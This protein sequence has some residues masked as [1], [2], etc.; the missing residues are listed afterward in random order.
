METGPLRASDPTVDP[1]P[2]VVAVVIPAFN[3]REGVPRTLDEL[4]AVLDTLDVSCEVVVV[5]DGSTDGTG[6]VAEA[7]GVRVVRLTSN[8]GYGAAL[9]AGIAATSSELVAIIDADGTYPADAL[10]EL[11]RRSAGI[12]MV[13]GARPADSANIPAIRRPGKRLLTRLAS[14]LS[15]TEIPDL[16]SGMR[17][18]RRSALER[19]L[20]ILPSGF[21]FTM[22]I[23]L[24]LLCTE[25]QVLY[26]PIEYRPRIGDSKLRATDFMTFL[27]L[28][29]RT[30]LLFNPLKVF[31]PLGG[32][33]FLVGTVKFV[34]DLFLWNLS[35]SVVMAFL[36]A[37]ILW[38][39]GLLADMIARLQLGSGSRRS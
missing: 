6:D 30:V 33:V 14:F 16:N 7:C 3:E 5:D 21:S 15:G 18:I 29:L 37:V 19:F 20:P 12:D 10:P 32:I 35:E 26:V 8:R 36:T 13:V 27:I 25:H 17:V 38:T 34:Y 9:K 31:L 28:V 1:D 22:T 2:R 4:M 23:T 11:L 39:V 24:S